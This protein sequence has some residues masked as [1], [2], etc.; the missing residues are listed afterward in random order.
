METWAEQ[1]DIDDDVEPGLSSV[2]AAELK[3]LRRENRELRRAID[4]LKRASAFVVSEL[5]RPSK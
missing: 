5:D 3:A 1:A 2:D 4:L